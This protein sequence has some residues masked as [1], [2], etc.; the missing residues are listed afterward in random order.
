MSIAYEQNDPAPK[1][2]DVVVTLCKNCVWS[3][4]DPITNHQLDCQHDRLYKYRSKNVE[5]FECQH[6]DGNYFTI[7][8]RTCIFC[9]DEKWL[10]RYH[11]TY[12]E[13]LIAETDISYDACIISNSDYIS[14]KRSI[15]SLDQQGL[16]PKK[17]TVIVD[18]DADD[19]AKSLIDY[20]FENAKC[21]WQVRQL[22]D[23]ENTHN[24][25]GKVID[26]IVEKQLS[27]F[28]TI[29]HAGY[30]YQQIFAELNRRIVFDLD[31]YPVILPDE[32]GNGLITTVY[33]HKLLFGNRGK[34][35][36]EKIKALNWNLTTITKFLS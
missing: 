28:Y 18:R 1:A 26:N 9:R 4:K 20:F 23:Y 3:V 22:A 30:K 12:D 14:V 17:I 25:I 21:S 11:E 8:G 34:P 10:D 7:N 24:D 16:L 32:D 29:C 36:L 5:V 13:Q 35:L 6:E 2:T 19:H 15:K 33:L 27:N 31:Q